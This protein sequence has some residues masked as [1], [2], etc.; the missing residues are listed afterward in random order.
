MSIVDIE[1]AIVA[2]VEVGV[3]IVLCFEVGVVIGPMELR[4]CWRVPAL[5]FQ[6]KLGKHRDTLVR[7]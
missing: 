6:D 7:W 4:N 2:G 3:V 1:V 5:G